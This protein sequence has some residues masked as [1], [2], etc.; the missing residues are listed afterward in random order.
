MRVVKD[1]QEGSH[2]L[3]KLIIALIITLSASSAHAFGSKGCGPEVSLEL[4]QDTG[5]G[6]SFAGPKEDVSIGLTLKWTLGHKEA[7]E[8]DQRIKAR[9]DSAAAT[10]AQAKVFKEK[11][12]I[13]KDFTH[14][15]AP[16]S[17]V[18]FCGDLLGVTKK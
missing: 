12:G 4:D 5:N 14:E 17:I 16:N 15:T 10:S 1:L 8:S 6:S 2:M 13:C 11:I 7:C 18:L 3:N 9:K